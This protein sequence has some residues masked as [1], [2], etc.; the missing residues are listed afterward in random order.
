MRRAGDITWQFLVETVTLA[1]IGGLLG[2]ALGG[3]GVYVLKSFTN[4]QAVIT[5]GALSLSMGISCLTG[6]V[7]GIY[8]ARRAARMDPIQALRHD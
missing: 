7:F 1:T 5:P 3:A 6:I 2:V 8:P 4:W